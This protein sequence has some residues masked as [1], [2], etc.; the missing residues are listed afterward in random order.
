MN[1][2]IHK[3]SELSF[4]YLQE[5]LNEEERLELNDFLNESEANRQFFDD[6]INQVRINEDL[7]H[8]YKTDSNAVWESVVKANP[9]LKKGTVIAFFRPTVRYAAAV[10]LIAALA[11]YW[12]VR[13]NENK[14]VAKVE[15]TQKPV[16]NNDIKPGQY[17]AKLTLDDGTTMI[18]DSAKNGRLVQQGGITVLNRDGKLIYEKG[19]QTNKVHYNKLVTAKGETFAAVLADGTKI[20]LNSESSISYPVSF[21]GQE[22]KVTITGE[23]YFEVAASVVRQGNKLVK[24]PF[25]VVVED[26]E[27]EV[28]GTHFNINA[29]ADEE[30]IKTTLLEGKVK[31]VSGNA[32]AMLMPGQQAQLTR[33]SNLLRVK[34]NV[35]VEE[36]V[37]W[38]NGYFQFNDADLKTVMRQLARWYDVD[39][40][41]QGEIGNDTYGGRINRNSKASE[42][43][44]LLGGNN[45]HYKIEGKKIIITP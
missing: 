4:K 12:L 28:L 19:G 35:D 43:M 34:D 18:L 2:P 1:K 14:Q 16:V 32:T 6:L 45:V 23:A 33:Q 37:A 7:E 15:T 38:K 39:V 21:I 11:G 27:V 26:M 31:V 5:G 44:N 41:Y 24:Q 9:R 36:A 10:I 17:K 42:V 22:R 13:H 30:A 25:K 40:V 20:W 8:I 29:Y 3:L